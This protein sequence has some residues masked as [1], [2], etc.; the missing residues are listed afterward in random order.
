MRVLRVIIIF[1]LLSVSLQAQQV[2]VLER[3]SNFPIENVTIYN[4]SNNTVVYTNKKGIADLTAFSNSDV[5]SFNHLAFIEYEILKKN[6]GIIEFVVYLNKK[7]E[8]LNE[9]VLSA[10]KGKESRSR[11]A[12]Q[13]DIIS[14]EE[15]KKLAPQTSADLLASL[16]GIK[17]QKTQAGGGSPVLR[18]MEAN[19]VLLVVDGV[20]MNNAIYR[21]GHLQNSITVSPNI[22]ERTEVIF[23]PSS[24]IYGSDAL[25]GVVHYYTKT[26]KVTTTNVNQVNTSLYSR[27]SSV[28]NEFTTEG[29]IELRNKKWASYTSIS[30]SEFGNLKMGKNRTHG[31]E[32]WGKVFDYSTNTN[33]F[34]TENSVT[35]SNVNTQENTDYNQTD[36]LQKITIPLSK[37]TELLF[38]FQYSTSSNIN[39]FDNL[40]TYFDDKLKYAEWYYGPQKRV[41]LSSQLKINPSKKWLQKGTITAAFQNIKE[42]RIDRRFSSLDR[43]YSFENLDVLSLNGD[44]FVPI[45]TSNDRIMSYGF[46]V[47]HNKVNSNAFGR[48]LEVEGNTVVGFSNQFI[49]QSRYPDGGSTYTS[50][51]SYVNYRQDISSKSTLNTGIRL[52]NTILTAKWID[53]TFITLPKPDISLHNSAIT[54]TLGYVYKPTV[55]W[56]LNSVIS[57]GFRSPN[58]DD[59]GKVREKSGNVTVPNINLKPEYAYSFET[60]AVR[61]FNNRKFH[62]G[63]NVYYTL[64]DNYITR[65]FFEIN[66]STTIVYNGEE[67]NVMANVNKNNAYIVGS[68]FSFK[69]YLSANWFTKGSLTY[70]K[71]KAYDTNLPLSSIPPLFGDIEI[72]YQNDRLQTIFLWKFNA[73][74]DIKDYN[75]IAGI[76]NEEQTPYNSITDTYYGNPGWSI[77]N[78]NTNY[79]LKN[80]ITLFMN[81]DNIFDV[82]YKEFASAISSPG[83][84]VSLSILLNL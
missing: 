49:E 83:R 52:S 78:F 74:K 26:P 77:F 54:A 79:K 70:T 7:S 58:I 71:G 62:T 36:V 61:Y 33:T 31:F 2:K 46:E 9:I 12:E 73:K 41:L 48:T 82:H 35:N 38:N 29:N 30:Y 75:L 81:I 1:L 68:T 69:G 60:G 84:N 43:Y 67:G 25:G 45:T 40:A 34:Y 24:V 64:L 17:V 80:N 16:P 55:K 18:G 23:G 37:K 66:N 10:S 65:D 11:V 6:L 76:D 3:E 47:T 22:I 72:G 4:D 15:I 63:L 13:I 51:A 32:D 50:F 42:S 44:F 20:R 59:V 39:R 57:S 19:R 21:T 27:F 14:K 53:D 5:I 56:Q 8:R 28:N